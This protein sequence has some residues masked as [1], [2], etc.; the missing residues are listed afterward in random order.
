MR[1]HLFFIS[2]AL[3]LLV[4][5][6]TGCAAVKVVESSAKRTPQWVY[7]VEQNFLIVSAEADNIETAKNKAL[8]EVK[9]QILNAIAEN[10]RSSSLMV[11]QEVGVDNFYTTLEMYQDQV[12]TE[13]GNVP[14]L[15]QVS[16]AN[17]TDYYWEKR[18]NKK[19]KIST[20]RYHLK[21]PFSRLDQ[22]QL[23]AKF[24]E[25]EKAINQQLEV[26]EQVDFSTF[27][28]V[29][30]MIAQGTAVRTFQSTLMEN[31][32]RRKTCDR[33]LRGYKSNIEQLSIHAVSVNRE[34]TIYEVF[35]GEKKVAC[36]IKPYLR[37]RCLEKMNW[38][39]VNG[40]NEVTYDYNGCYEDE[41]NYIDITLTVM[42]KKINHRFFIL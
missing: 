20:Y 16:L 29:E 39:V 23:V 10:V 42:G 22:E 4:F 14:F 9:K 5:S 7:G 24:E 3:F 19:T 38:Q 6:C 25:Q 37:T 8:N 35:Y 33:I 1:H 30:Q 28:S 36:N 18:Y 13:S 32:T 17:A 21:Y 11:S 40:V 27:A 12:T 34:K 41:E 31:D 26:F 2:L 15:S